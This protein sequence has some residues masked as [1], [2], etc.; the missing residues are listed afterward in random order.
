LIH[1]VVL[2]LLSR[3]VWLSIGC[4]GPD[5]QIARLFSD[6]S[7]FGWQ[8]SFAAATHHG[9][10]VSRDIPF[11]PVKIFRRDHAKIFPTNR[12]FTD[13]WCRDRSAIEIA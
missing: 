7:H 4:R 10:S 11:L 3:D 5:S 13:R 9:G 8:L 1:G 12:T 2:E 6:Q